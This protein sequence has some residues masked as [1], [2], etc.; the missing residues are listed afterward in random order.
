MVGAGMSLALIPWFKLEAWTVPVPIVGA[1]KLQPFGLLAAIAIMVGSRYFE[2]RARQLALSRELTNSFLGWT[3]GVGLVSA[4]VLNVVMYSPELF[5]EIAR[6]P[7]LLVRHWYGLSS[8]GGFVGGTSAAIIFANRREASLSA[9]GDAW[10]YAFPFAWFFARLGC[11]VVHDHPGL[12][13]DFFLAVDDY[14]GAGVARHDLG[15]YEVLWCLP[16]A[17]YFVWRGRRPAPVGLYLALIPLSYGP[18]RFALDFLR[19]GSSEGGDVRYFG[20]TPAQYLSLLLTLVGCVLCLGVW[21]RREDPGTAH[22]A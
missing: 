20:L 10:C 1:I 22:T 8:Y 21:R 6:D 7:R 15:L 2:S 5:Q 11:F 3:T 17:A 16:V 9:L 18:V 13:S 12:P 14:N 4:C 19:A